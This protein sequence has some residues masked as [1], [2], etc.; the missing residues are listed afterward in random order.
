MR[1]VFED[2]FQR[3]LVL[4]FTFTVSLASQ[5]SN[6]SHFNLQHQNRLLTS[7]TLR[8]ACSKHFKESP[9]LS[10]IEGPMKLNCM[11]KTF[12]PR[13]LCKGEQKLKSSFTRALVSDDQQSIMCEFAT[14]VKLNLNCGHSLIKKACEISAQA[15]CHVMK[16]NY[17]HD[18]NLVH[19]AKIQDGSTSLADCHFSNQS[20]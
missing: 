3:S 13:A 19:A 12:N 10:N 2:Y 8:D 16:K 7:Y 6:N 9:I 4:F 14:M 20:F 18:L 5:G 17:A 11:G 15:A 1:C